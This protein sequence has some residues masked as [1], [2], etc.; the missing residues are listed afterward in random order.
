MK[1]ERSQSQVKL[2]KI[3]EDWLKQVGYI[4]KDKVSELLKQAEENYKNSEITD[5]NKYLMDQKIDV[6]KTLN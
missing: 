2:R 4:N 6:L 3:Q 1:K 5:Q